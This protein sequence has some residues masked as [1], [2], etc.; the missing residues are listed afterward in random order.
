MGTRQWITEAARNLG[1][2]NGIRLVEP[3]R[4]KSIIEKI[5]TERTRLSAGAIDRLWWW[6]ALKEPVA[7]KAPPDPITFIQGILPADAAIWFVAEAGGQKRIGNFWLYEGT[8]SV[9]C[10]VLRDCPPF[11]YYIVD[12]K[13]R[14]LVCENHHGYVIG[15]GEPIVQALCEA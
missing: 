6:E 12:K 15:S 1:N 10:A 5:V 3:H 14:W 13:M 8:P 9:V 11:E 4:F 2:E 7:S